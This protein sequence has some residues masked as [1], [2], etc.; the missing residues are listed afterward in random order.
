M[1]TVIQTAVDCLDSDDVAGN[2]RN[3]FTAM[4]ATHAK[5][6]T[7]KA[8]YFELR[9]IILDVLTDACKLNEEQREAWVVFFNCAINT[10]FGEYDKYHAKTIKH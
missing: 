2:L 4:G 9:G 5:R 1:Q 10:I 7:P 8:S 3:T 6:H